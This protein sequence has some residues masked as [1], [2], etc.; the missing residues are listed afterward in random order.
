VTL[1]AL[2]VYIG[3]VR[4]RTCFSPGYHKVLQ[5]LYIMRKVLSEH[6][7]SYPCRP[8]LREIGVSSTK[9]TETE[10]RSIRE[11]LSAKYPTFLDIGVTTI[12]PSKRL[13]ALGSIKF[14]QKTGQLM[15][16][17]ISFP[18][19]CL[20]NLV[21]YWLSLEEYLGTTIP[22]ERL[23]VKINGDDIAFRSNETHYAIWL[24]WIGKAGFSLSLGKNYCHPSLVTLNSVLYECKSFRT[25]PNNLDIQMNYSIREV[26]YFNTGLLYAQS[27]GKVQD[28]TRELS[29]EEMYRIVIGDAED[30]IRAHNRFLHHNLFQIKKMTDNGRY[31]LFLPRILGGLGFPIFSEV[32]PIIRF[33][34]FQRRFGRFFLN[35]IREEMSSGR[36]PKKFLF[37]FQAESSDLLSTGVH[38]HSG[39]RSY[40]LFPP[41]PLPEGYIRDVESTL[42]F[43]GPFQ[44]PRLR[45][46]NV[47]YRLPSRSVL[48]AFKR[49][50]ENPGPLSQSLSDREIL[51][52]Q[53]LQVAFK[54]S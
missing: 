11:K 22:V 23:P 38:R 27:K 19:L 3:L 10:L 26:P 29:L 47:G 9:C 33:T 4:S 16:S 17:P 39:I 2:D 54:R 53:A 20:I 14:L 51:E 24:R 5:Y 15:G 50:Q 42:I 8:F 43:L 13:V 32:F 37:A 31:N 41:G 7:L 46:D 34:P 48:R 44:A 35:S 30:K 52:H 45:V 6:I 1:L 21:A 49:Y 18:F 25:G 28:W 36:Y 12:D 40:E